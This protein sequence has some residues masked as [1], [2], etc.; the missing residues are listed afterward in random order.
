MTTRD[1]PGTVALVEFEASQ[2]TSRL[3]L[4]PKPSN[5][6]NEPLNWTMPRKLF[7]YT[8]ILAMVTA[9]F[10]LIT[11]QAVYWQ[12]MGPDMG[13]DLQQLNNGNSTQLA[14]LAV[15][16]IFFIPFAVK[17]G[18]RPVY[19]V[20]TALLVASCWWTARMNTYWEVIVTNFLVGL[21]GSI[22]ETTVQMTIADLFF[23]HQRGTANGVYFVAVMIGSFLTPMAGGAQAA[24]QGWRWSYYALAIALSILLVIFVFTFEETKYIPPRSLT[25]V[26]AAVVENNEEGTNRP[27]GEKEAA[28]TKDLDIKMSPSNTL[29]EVTPPLNTYRQRM[30]FTTTTN[31]SLLRV[32][33]APAKVIFFP[34]VIFTG[35]QFASGVCFLVQLLLM[36]SILFSAPPYNFDTAG[37]GL[38]AMGPFIGNIFG[39]IYGGP[40]SD[41]CIKFF[42]R[43]NGGTFEPEM[44]LY[45]LLPPAIF[46][47]GGLAMFGVT[48]G[49]GM[50]WIYPSV[51]GAFFAFGLGANGDIVF[52]FVIDSYRDL[53][54]EAFV[55]IAFLRNAVSIC[56]PL[57][58]VQ[59]MTQVGPVYMFV[60]SS[61]IILFIA[62]LFI[63]MI[64][65]GK[66]I[67]IALAPRYYAIIEKRM[68]HGLHAGL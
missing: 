32:F 65:W 46:M 42:A 33:V 49:M 20:S 44:R 17:Y 9:G 21:A 29:G 38:M 2:D 4:V 8:L 26:L 11:I 6:P 40:F 41:W 55:G 56:I 47:S 57:T 58:A 18:R 62:L 54:A 1:P 5:D 13:L 68:Q 25:T 59:W 64:I 27:S 67:R 35:L 37:V 3:I 14:G 63:P 19:L 45:T 23:V 51:G 31:E 34:H 22:N 48:A 66:K 12:Q 52:T 39:A 24:A 15:G 53:V 60:T 28:D 43:R 50:H 30:R 7:H 36:T 10:T 16:C 61:M